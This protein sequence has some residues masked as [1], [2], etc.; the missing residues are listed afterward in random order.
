MKL[1]RLAI[2]TDGSEEKHWC[3]DLNTF[4]KYLVKFQKKDW[5]NVKCEH[6]ASKFINLLGIKSHK[7]KLIKTDIGK[8][9]TG[10]YRL[11]VACKDF[12]QE[13]GELKTFKENTDSMGTDRFNYQYS[14]K[15]IL[16]VLFET[17]K[18]DDMKVLNDFWNMYICD[19]IL[20]NPDRHWGNW[21][22]CKN[23]C[24][25][26]L[27]PIFDN[28]ASLLP[29]AKFRP[30]TTNCSEEEW[31]YT[32]VYDFPNSK[33][34]FENGVRERSSYI[35]TWN[36]KLIPN[37]LKQIYYNGWN[38]GIIQDILYNKLFQG[39]KYITI[40]EALFIIKYIELRY[41]CIIMGEDFQSAYLNTQENI[42]IIYEKWQY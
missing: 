16:Y 5:E 19:L 23:S 21:G 40:D 7:T 31:W 20:A 34:I 37:G 36:S 28:G 25:R 35:D 33:I 26:K 39:E 17:H 1:I 13:Y 32:R 3:M 12:T 24:G 41:R 4:D 38:N 14:F 2:K 29:R 30:D 22:I 42:A 27:S 10:K 6:I 8:E 15:D 9:D 18:L 11:A